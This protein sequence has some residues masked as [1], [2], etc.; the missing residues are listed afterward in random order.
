MSNVQQTAYP[1]DVVLPVCYKCHAPMELKRLN[2]GRLHY[3][4]EFQCDACGRSVTA[5]VA[6][7]STLSPP[8]A[9]ALTERIDG[10]DDIGRE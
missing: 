9:S 3:V 10:G 4:G 5:V 8:L 2:R 6:L 1:A 7:R